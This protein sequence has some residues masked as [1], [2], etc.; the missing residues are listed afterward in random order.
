MTN[1]QTNPPALG[2]RPACHTWQGRRRRAAHGRR[3]SGFLTALLT[4][5]G[6]TGPLGGGLGRRHLRRTPKSIAG[7][8]Y[9]L[10]SSHAAIG[11]Y[12]K[13]KI[14][15]TD[16]DHCWW[17]EGGKRQT[18]HHLFTECR[19]WIPQTRRLWRDI[20]KAHGWKHPKAPSGKW[21]WMETSTE[22]GL[23]FWGAPG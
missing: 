21:L 1:K 23:A 18:R 14:R 13:D 17:C 10:L 19:A 20:G 9:Q 16:D 22:A 12:L 11:P 8:Y 4:L 2:G 6:G 3:R 15:K 7:R 5:G